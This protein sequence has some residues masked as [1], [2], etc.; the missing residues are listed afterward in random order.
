MNRDAIDK[1]ILNDTRPAIHQLTF[2]ALFVLV[3]ISVAVYTSSPLFKVSENSEGKAWRSDAKID[4]SFPQAEIY[5]PKQQKAQFQAIVEGSF[6]T[7]A[8][9]SGMSASQVSALVNTVSPHFDFIATPKENGIFYAVFDELDPESFRVFFYEDN[10]HDFYI[11]RYF[12]NALY[13][14]HAIPFAGPTYLNAPTKTSFSVSSHFDHNRLHPV[15]NR[16]T[17]HYGTDYPTPIGTPI[18]AIGRGKVTVSKYDRLAGNHITIRH[19][20]GDV[21]RYFH[22]H[23]RAVSAG[24][25]IE[26][27]EQIGISGNTGRTT[28]PHLHFEFWRDGTAMDFEK[29]NHSF[30]ETLNA[31]AE[32]RKNILALFN[33]HLAS[34]KRR[35][36]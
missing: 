23:K 20:N 21:S 25:Y 26:I 8:L 11:V 7:S 15:T 18:I 17:P 4:V 22:L 19:E 29:I 34:F 5:L 27:G 31:S 1:I 12:D 32:N 36:Q 16:V 13:N 10:Q 2:A 6:F 14:E 24:D 3:A 35:E 9:D 28:G 30:G 33:K